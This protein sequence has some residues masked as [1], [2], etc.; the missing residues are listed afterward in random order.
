MEKEEISYL[1]EQGFE[2]SPYICYKNTWT[3]RAR[4]FEL[5]L[6]PNET[7]TGFLQIE[8]FENDGCRT[9]DVTLVTNNASNG[10][11]DAIWILRTSGGSSR[12]AV[13]KARDALRTFLENALEQIKSL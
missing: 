9:A 8:V 4:E 7:H 2:E 13:V 6:N 10:C 1:K 12:E 11:E 3:D 5:S